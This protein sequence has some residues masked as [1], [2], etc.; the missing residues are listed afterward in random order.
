VSGRS[1]ERV[2]CN[3]CGVP[4]RVVYVI[5]TAL[6]VLLALSGLYT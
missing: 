2:T 5:V 3:G 1:E 4:E 6:S